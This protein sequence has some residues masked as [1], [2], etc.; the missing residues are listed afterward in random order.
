MCFLVEFFFLF[1]FF[2]LNWN[3]KEKK[4][5]QK[6][7]TYLPSYAAEMDLRIQ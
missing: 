5:E 4:K 3:R 7:Q 2:F 1:G 6:Y